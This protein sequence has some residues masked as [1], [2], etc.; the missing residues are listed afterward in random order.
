V[1]ADIGVHNRQVGYGVVVLSAS[2]T[3]LQ[4]SP[5]VRE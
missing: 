3:I 4:V 2:G 5:V 1:V